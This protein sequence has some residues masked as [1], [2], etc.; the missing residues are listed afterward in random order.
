[1]PMPKAFVA[2][3]TLLPVK[4]EI[5]LIF[6]P[7]FLGKPCMVARGGNA[8]VAQKLAHPLDACARGAVDDTGSFPRAPAP[9]QQRFCQL[10]VRMQHLKIE[11]RAVEAR[12][13]AKRVSQA[14]G[15]R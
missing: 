10:A 11:V 7:F 9:A 12:D 4:A 13:V 3:M 6:A 8:A 14:P 5:V 1:M 15:A 2:T